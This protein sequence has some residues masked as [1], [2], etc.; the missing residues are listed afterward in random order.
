M[1]HGDRHDDEPQEGP[2]EV[3]DDEHDAPLGAPPDPM[4][5]VWLHPTELSGLAGARSAPDS[6]AAPSGSEPR[7]RRGAAWLIPLAAGATGAVVAV[8]V[9]ALA[10]AFDRT[11]TNPQSSSSDTGTA[12]SALSAD[13]L[14]RLGASVVAVVA[15][16]ANGTRRGSAVCVRHD[17]E[18]LTAASVVGSAA[19]VDVFTAD[20]QR[21]AGKVLGRDPVTDLALV[22][23]NTATIDAAQLASQSPATGTHVWLL[24]ATPTGSTSPWMSGGIISSNNATVVAS[25]GPTTAGLLQSDAAAGAAA[26]GGALLDQQGNVTAVVL[27]RLGNDATT[28]A[29]P[30]TTAVAV[31]AQLHDDGRAE[32]GTLGF[33]GID[34]P[35]GPAVMKVVAKGPAARAGLRPGDIVEAVNGHYV[36]SISDVTAWVRSASPGR[37]VQLAIRRGKN[38]IEMRAVLGATSG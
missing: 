11:T 32:H 29:V 28:Y 18:L 7:R 21:H 5:R 22:S 14:S 37:T 12:V 9:L 13:T 19:T 8:I 33:E 10:G 34:S 2:D 15:R 1:G 3:P 27:G 23:V 16:D 4:D 35:S 25:P 17:G 31:A 24:G 20:G 6:P 36:E 30:I 38:D 26:S